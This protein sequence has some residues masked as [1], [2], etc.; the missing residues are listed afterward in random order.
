MNNLLPVAVG[1]L[2]SGLLMS[3]IVRLVKSRRKKTGARALS[4][5]ELLRLI[6]FNAA[7]HAGPLL[8]SMVLFLAGLLL[9]AFML[10]QTQGN[11]LSFVCLI[12][13]LPMII[14]FRFSAKFQWTAGVAVGFSDAMR[15]FNENPDQFIDAI[16]LDS[17]YLRVVSRRPKW[18]QAQY[19]KFSRMRRPPA[20]S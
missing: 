9:T 15:I 10:V 6:A 3:V 20:D 12:A 13:G 8:T 5:D 18:L 19:L 16:L 2:I 4:Q 17:E 1:A 14:Q 7:V 11:M